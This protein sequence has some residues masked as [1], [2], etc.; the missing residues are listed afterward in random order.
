MPKLT[1]TSGR[2]LDSAL[3]AF[4]ALSAGFVAFAMPDSV[5]AGIV[6]ASRL[7]A[8]VP[9]AQPPLGD[10]ARYAAVGAALL[11]TFA[12]VWAL[13]AALGRAPA[14]RDF[15]PE[16]EAAPIRPRRADAHPDAPPRPP[17][18]APDLG[19]P[20]ELEEVA[21]EPVEE[22]PV[23]QAGLRPLPGFLLPEQPEPEPVAEAHQSEGQP[24]P[25]PGPGPRPEPEPESQPEPEAV[26]REA[27]GQ[28]LPIA[29][30]A[31]RLPDAGDE[32]DQSLSQLVN[33][34][35]FGLSSRK[36]QALTPTEPPAAE[37]P[38]AE[39]PERVGHRLRSAIN[40]LQKI[41]SSGA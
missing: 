32:G 33:R 17:L 2:A 30:L 13:M 22:Q 29:G 25:E 10:T 40:D 3:A 39:E 37:E 38:A 11:F 19:E 41:A 6:E 31:A 28:P 14:R 26:E 20:I 9:A 35:E 4:A 8:V 5:F 21:E 15:V 12:A 16:P 23:E 34:I 36:R 24:E 27:E 7:P 1:P 18:L